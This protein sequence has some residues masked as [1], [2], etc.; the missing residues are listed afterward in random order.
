MFGRRRHVAAVS[1]APIPQ[2]SEEQILELVH[3]KLADFVGEHGEWTVSRRADADTDAIFHN[4]LARSVA[5][6]ITAAIMDAKRKLE[7][8]ET[9]EA[10]EPGLHVAEEPVS[11][12]Q[13]DEPAAFG[14]EPAP[15]TVWT[16]LRRPVTG[17][18]PAIIERTAA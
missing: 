11:D 2:L 18:I 10:V 6:G 7:T 5:V 3:Q 16:D 12:L 1:A 8:G 15:I 9:V 17:E 13:H 14:W 4:I